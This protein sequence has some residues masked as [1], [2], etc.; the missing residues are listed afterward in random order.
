MRRPTLRPPPENTPAL[1]P[2][3]AL[4][5]CAAAAARAPALCALV[6][7]HYNA[8]VTRKPPQP[9]SAFALSLAFLFAA[10]WLAGCATHFGPGY[11]VLQQKIQVRFSP[12]PQPLLEITAEYRL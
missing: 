8:C 7:R 1:I 4:S 5:A 12:E 10:C 3:P 2:A 9:V 11:T 6:P